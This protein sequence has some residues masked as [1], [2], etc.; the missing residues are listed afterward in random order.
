M[1]PSKLPE[2]SW[3]KSIFEDE[4]NKGAKGDKKK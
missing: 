4:Q 3:G 2:M 1:K